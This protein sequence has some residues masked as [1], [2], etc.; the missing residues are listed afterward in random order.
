[1]KTITKQC[2]GCGNNFLLSYYERNRQRYCTKECAYKNRLIF[3]RKVIEDVVELYVDQKKSL[4][5]VAL[6]VGLKYHN[7]RKILSDQKINVR[8]NALQQKINFEIN[9]NR[10][11]GSS[12]KSCLSTM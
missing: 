10:H 8:T 5:D 11:N 7:I 6:L 9:P 2:I 4:S 1:M 12:S 3:D